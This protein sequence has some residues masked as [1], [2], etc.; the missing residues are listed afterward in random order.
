VETVE[1]DQGILERLYAVIEEELGVD[2]RAVDPEKNFIFELGLDSV[3]LAAVAMRID[4]EFEIS[5][6]MSIIG[7]PT[8]AG[9]LQEFKRQLDAKKLV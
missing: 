8:M 7:A 1:I 5:L 3:Q 2:P 9:F 6:P 4:M